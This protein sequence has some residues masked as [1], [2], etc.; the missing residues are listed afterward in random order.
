MKFSYSLLKQLV[1][2][3]KNKEH[4]AEILSLYIFEVDGVVG[5]TLD[6]KVLPNRYSDAASHLGLAREI[7]AALGTRVNLGTTSTSSVNKA[8]K[9]EKARGELGLIVK[10]EDKNCHRY[11]ARYFEIDKMNET[12]DWMKKV[13]MD[14]GMRPI[15]AFVD[16]MNYV[17]LEVGQPMHAFDAD[18]LE[19]INVRRAKNNEKIITLDG[20]AYELGEGDLIIADG[21]YPLAIA[22]IKGGKRA[23]VTNGTK[24]IIVESANFDYVSVYKTSKKLKLVTDASSRFAHN[25]S[26]ALAE[27]GL[28]RATD[29]LVEI[30]GARVGNIADIY[31]KKIKPVVIKYS[32]E[33]LYQLT[34]LKISDAKALG[35]LKTLGFEIK[36][37]NIKAPV[38]RTDIERFE[39]LVDEIVRLN[40]YNNLPAT[41]PHAALRPTEHDAEVLFKNKLRSILQGLGYS[42]S[43]NYSFVSKKELDMIGGKFFG[44]AMVLENPISAD[45]EYLR[46]NLAIG[47]LKNTE[48]NFR[49]YDT[50]RMFEIG[51]VFNQ[52]DGQPINENLKLGIIL[53]SKKKHPILELKGIIDILLERLGLTDYAFEDLNMQIDFLYP[54]ESLRIESD[55]HVLGYV[56]MVQKNIASNIAIGEIDLAHLLKLV[57]E[58]KEYEPIPK[59]PSVERDI[60]LIVGQSVRV[61]DILRFIQGVAPK[62]IY[63]VDLIDYYEDNSK[64]NVNEK[65]LTFRIVFQADDRTLTDVEVGHQMEKI[66]GML[67]EQFNAEIR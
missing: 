19:G 21:E 51:H 34:G 13:L 23:E 32:G 4:L 54:K 24:R 28:L 67:K 39:D 64:M 40:G 37:K 53:G 65:S 35:F 50:V 44:E 18:K 46:S 57:E 8:K 20:D 58:E 59:Y 30:C 25:L 22:G 52:N 56:G 62:I 48:A 55:H 36:G 17:M 47:L 41:P 43:Y 6:V 7:A 45:F 26:P 38:R 11:M 15:N 42:E 14:C 5:D 60:S 61:G 3:I 31:H 66:I 16:I 2:S 29:L 33:K 9:F 12:P 10:A 63:D 1:P 49:F 27:E